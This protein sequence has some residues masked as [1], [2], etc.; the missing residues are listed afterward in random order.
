MLGIFMLFQNAVAAVAPENH[1][2]IAPVIGST[3]NIMLNLYF[4]PTYGIAGACMASF[5][6][7]TAATVAAAILLHRTGRI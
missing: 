4:I 3:L 2:P 1:A 7:Y 6:A 5:I